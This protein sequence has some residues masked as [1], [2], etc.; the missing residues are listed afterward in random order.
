MGKLHFNTFGG[1]PYQAM[2]GAETIDI[3]NDEKLINNADEMGSYIKE[4]FRDLQKDFPIIGDVRGRGLLMGLELVKDPKTKE[5]ATAE[6]AD[7]MEKAKDQ[8]ILIGKGG[9]YG[10]VVR[11]APSLTLTKAECDEFLKGIRAAF[12]NLGK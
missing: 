12:E 4:G 7:L 3:I 2:P 10:N 11:I 8:G 6:C 9:L 1:D 5:P